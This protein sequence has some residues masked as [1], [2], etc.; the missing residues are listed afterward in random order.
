MSRFH[1]PQSS[2]RP[3]LLCAQRRPGSRHL[4]SGLHLIIHSR[5]ARHEEHGAPG[6]GLEEDPTN[7]RG[8]IRSGASQKFPPVARAIAIQILVRIGGGI[9]ELKL[10]PP[11]M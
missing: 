9:G 8:V 5:H 10:A 3:R 7:A 4:R 11:P 6:L 2:A 1:D